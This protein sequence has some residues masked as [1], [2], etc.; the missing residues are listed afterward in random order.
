MTDGKKTRGRPALSAAEKRTHNLTF[1]ARGDMR[2]RL[3]SAAA[4]HQ[5]SISEEI[6]GRLQQSFDLETWL[7]VRVSLPKAIAQ[8]IAAAGGEYSPDVMAR[9]T[10]MICEAYFKGPLSVPWEPQE[11]DGEPD[12]AALIAFAVLK[13]MGIAT[14]QEHPEGRPNTGLLHEQSAA[15]GDIQQTAAPQGGQHQR[16]RIQGAEDMLNVLL[17]GNR[18]KVEALRRFTLEIAPIPDADFSEA[19][20]KMSE[21]ICETVRECLEG[22]GS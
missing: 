1:R 8:A 18:E 22:G 13:G 9:A 20:A 4:A 16:A 17:G 2:E 11:Q 6:E 10:M 5:K 21:R 3:A 19:A 15:H 12:P 7:G 14:T